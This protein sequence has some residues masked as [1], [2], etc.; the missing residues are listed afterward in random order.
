[1]RPFRLVVVALLLPALVS[2]PASARCLGFDVDR[3]VR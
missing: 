1:M 2:E 3:L